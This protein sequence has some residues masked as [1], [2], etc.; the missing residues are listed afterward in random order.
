MIEVNELI[1]YEEN[2]L[3]DLFKKENGIKPIL[4]EIEKAC[5]SLVFDPST[6]QGRKDAKSLARKV[7]SSKTLLVKIGKE[8]V[9]DLKASVSIADRQ[10][11]DAEKFL[12]DLR[13]RIKKEADEWELREEKRVSDIKEKIKIVHEACSLVFSSLNSAQ[14]KLIELGSISNFDF[15]EFKDE[16]SVF[17]NQAKEN[18]S[19]EISRLEKEEKEKEELEQLRREKAEREEKERQELIEK[20]RA[21]REERIRKEA[22]EKAKLD[23]ENKAREEKERL[24]REARE[25]KERAE[26]A[27]IQRKEQEERSRIEQEKAI[28]RA[29]E[30]ERKRLQDEENKK[31][32]DQKKREA[33]T[34]NKKRVNNEALED[35]LKS[36]SIVESE[37]RMI[38]VAIATGKI[39]NVKINY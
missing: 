3:I 29:K 31:I 1:K 37:A 5:L 8:S 24:E 34:E 14:E 18:I 35:L 19:R 28:E 23:A 32:A 2:Q 21:E 26:R 30:Q 17:F 20:E 27:E 12:D 13:D 7:S 15:Q 16:A 36:S 38:I 11:I 39:R 10:R 4:E 6:E 33:D 9:A 22:E 25:A